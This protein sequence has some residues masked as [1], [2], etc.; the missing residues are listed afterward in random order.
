MNHVRYNLDNIP[1]VQKIT[2][3]FNPT[4]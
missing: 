3:G 1:G 4:P 2:G